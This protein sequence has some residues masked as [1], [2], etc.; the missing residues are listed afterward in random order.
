MYFDS[1]RQFIYCWK[2]V[3]AFHIDEWIV[4]TKFSN[5]DWQ[6]FHVYEIL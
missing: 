4:E 6:A 1:I 2:V 3:E 5:N